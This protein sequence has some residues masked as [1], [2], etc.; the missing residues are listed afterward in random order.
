MLVCRTVT[1]CLR[2]VNVLK[3]NYYFARG[4]G[5]E[6]GGAEIASTGK[7]KYGKCKY[8]RTHFVRMENAS[9]ENTSTNV[10]GWKTQV[11]RT[12]VR[13]TYLASHTIIQLASVIKLIFYSTQRHA[14]SE[15]RIKSGKHK[16]YSTAIVKPD[17]SRY[18]TST[19]R[20]MRIGGNECV[21]TLLTKSCMSTT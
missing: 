15:Q 20:T 9:T 21:D 7:H 19:H 3:F 17:S 10:Q 12:Q 1:S 14:K 8:K 13:I 2:T 6:D 16:H 11:R 4:S 5:C 18:D